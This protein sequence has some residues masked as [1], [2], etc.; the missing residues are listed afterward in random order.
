MSAGD[1]AALEQTTFARLELDAKTL[2]HRQE[3]V[4][5]ERLRAEEL[6]AFEE[7][8]AHFER[9]VYSL[10]FRILG[11]AEEARDAA[12]ETFLKVYRGL[13]GF[14][15][16]SGL[17]TWIY[18]IAINQAMNQQRWW[19]RRHRDET[20]SLDLSRGDSE[21]TIESSLR[22]TGASP[23]QMAISSERERRIM[24]ALGE[25]KQEYR[26]ALILRE[27]EDLSYEEIAETLAISIGTVKSRIA[28][29]REELRR[30]VKGLI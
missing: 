13:K 15:G 30:R 5:L 7:M 18:R 23:E 8:V 20:I 27:I 1:M 4:L 2:E 24:K 28:R 25:V 17:K 9:P 22:G 10:C 11:D 12:Q 21:I 16:E 6:A 14:R 3:R 19:R 26:V 29:G